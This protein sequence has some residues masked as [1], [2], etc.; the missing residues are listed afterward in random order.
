MQREI[1][2]APLRD[3]TPV[4]LRPIRPDDAERLH[5]LFHRL[6]PDTVYLRFFSTVRHPTRTSSAT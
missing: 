3:G 5:R 4:V 1:E 2:E 6:S